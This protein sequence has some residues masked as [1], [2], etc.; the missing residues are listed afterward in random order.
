M[1]G[2]IPP[3]FLYAFLEWTRKKKITSTFTFLGKVELVDRLY[4]ILWPARRMNC[5]VEWST[6]PGL[7]VPPIAIRATK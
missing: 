4:S 5:A 3:L 6:S 7:R 1:S 2:D